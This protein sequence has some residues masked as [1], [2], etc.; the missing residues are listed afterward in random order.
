MASV[1]GRLFGKKKK[2]EDFNKGEPVEKNKRLFRLSDFEL[3]E[4]L[5]RGTFSRVRL[6]R[7]AMDE[8]HYAIKIL[9][10]NA[11]KSLAT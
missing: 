4:T 3:K 11:A 2:V 6:A 7:H 10:K 8:Q 1:A 9:K 5:G